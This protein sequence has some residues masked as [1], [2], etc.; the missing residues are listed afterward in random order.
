MITL[1]GSF[2]SPLPRCRTD[3]ITEIVVAIP[4]VTLV[5]TKLSKIPN[6]FAET[7]A[8]IPTTVT[9]KTKIILLLRAA[10]SVVLFGASSKRLQLCFLDS[11]SLRQVMDF[12]LSNHIQSD[13]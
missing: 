5:D 11:F 3:T 12:C 10:S 8:P 9:V 1:H 4:A 2:Q 6:G 7:T 13:G